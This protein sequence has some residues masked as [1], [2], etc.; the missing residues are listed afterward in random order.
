[1]PRP[2]RWMETRDR[3]W[4]CDRPREPVE[5]GPL[6]Q[7]FRMPLYRDDPGGARIRRLGGLDH[8]IVGPRH[9]LEAR[10]DVPNCLMVPAV[11]GRRTSAEGPLEQRPG[12]D[13]HR[14]I[15]RFIVRHRTRP[16]TVQILI[17]S[18]SEGDVE[19]LNA[20]AD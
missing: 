15:T 19:D 20:A 12:I 2:T 5:Q 17:Q 10:R 7:I 4:S 6:R 8:A 16:L 14:V 3:S 11:H 1:M 18:A 13:P 9:R